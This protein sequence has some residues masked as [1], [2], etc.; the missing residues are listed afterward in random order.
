MHLRTLITTS[1]LMLSV[2]TMSSLGVAPAMAQTAE[3][4]AVEWNSEGGSTF[5]R[6]ET[7]QVPFDAVFDNPNGV[8]PSPE[9]FSDGPGG[10]SLP[11]YQLDLFSNGSYNVSTTLTLDDYRS[12]FG[13]WSVDAQGQIS[14]ACPETGCEFIPPVQSDVVFIQSPD[15]VPAFTA[16]AEHL[17]GSDIAFYYGQTRRLVCS[18]SDRTYKLKIPST[19]NETPEPVDSSGGCDYT[20]AEVNGGWG[21]DAAN[22]LSCPPAADSCDYS[23]AALNDGWG[24][25]PVTATSCP[26]L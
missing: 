4:L 14:F 15:S 22:G 24:W 7:Y 12:E 23:S 5:C 13:L 18:T 20:D 6:E 8:E 9:W 26:P 1:G 16:T 2:L 25:N 10:F 11:G 21:W 3:Q 17:G 19:D